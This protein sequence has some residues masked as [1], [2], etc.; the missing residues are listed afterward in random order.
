MIVGFRPRHTTSH[1]DVAHK[2]TSFISLVVA[3][4]MTPEPRGI[5]VLC[6]GTELGSQISPSDKASHACVFDWHCV[7]RA[8]LGIGAA[9]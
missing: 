2:E 1:E 3:W 9:G 7:P 5:G 8:K 4:G 6:L